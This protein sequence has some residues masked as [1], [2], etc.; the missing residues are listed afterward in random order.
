MT[1]TD[2][3]LAEPTDSLQLTRQQ[4]DRAAELIARFLPLGERLEMTTRLVNLRLA[5]DRVRDD[6]FS[7]L[8]MG[9][10]NRG[11]S[12]LINAL[13]GRK[14]LPTFATETTATICEVH[15]GDTPRA[16]LFPFEG[17]PIETNVDDLERFVAVDEN[18]PSKPSPYQKVEVYWPVHLCRNG[19]VLVDSPGLNKSLSH[20]ERTVSYL[21]SADAIVFVAD[22]QNAWSR[23]EVGFVRQIP[24]GIDP[25]FV[26]NKINLVDEEERD[27]LRRSVTRRLAEIQ[28]TGVRR[29]YFVDAKRALAAAGHDTEVDRSG[30]GEF[31]RDLQRFLATD[32]A[33][34]KI[35]APARELAEAVREARKQI[36]VRRGQLAMPLQEA[37]ERVDA[38]RRPLAELVERRAAIVRRVD[39]AGDDLVRDVRRGMRQFLADTAANVPEWARLADV[40][41]KLS[42][43]PFTA[44]EVAKEFMAELGEKI[45]ERI[46]E[47]YLEWREGRLAVLMDRHADDLGEDLEEDLAAFESRLDGVRFGLIPDHLRVAGSHRDQDGT[48]LA[49]AMAAAG[50]ML[51]AGPGGAFVG[52]RLGPTQMLRSAIPQVAAGVGILMFTPLGLA[53]AAIAM[54]AIGVIK[55]FGG[56][57]MVGDKLRTAVAKEFV[58]NITAGAADRAE[59]FGDEIAAEMKK[60]GATIDPGLA[61]R[62][63]ELQ[64][65]LAALRENRNRDRAEMERGM[66]E[67][68]AMETQLDALDDG[69]A[70]LL[71]GLGP[72]VPAPRRG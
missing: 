27:R 40:S 1:I 45:E 22:S 43:N 20:E 49:R 53:S 16:R 19:V 13:V 70:D 3:V 25:F 24:P 54:A 2:D 14:V 41:V 64:N 21:R 66:A 58:Q 12:T 59:K 18:D 60:F 37:E 67:L 32:R 15:Y 48:P 65:Q 56:M 34:V 39:E 26:F 38:Q 61:V 30:V 35:G 72:A 4:R 63:E 31:V 68:D 47:A 6:T 57:Q 9:E 62:I 11:K 29:H 10:F 71:A 52:A 33:A 69:I 44:D 42:V 50:G 36:P 46:A 8:V 7:V 5:A 55:V 28:P 17:G 51:L 23:S